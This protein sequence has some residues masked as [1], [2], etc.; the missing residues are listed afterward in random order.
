MK[1]QALPR[2]GNGGRGDRVPRQDTAASGAGSVV[3]PCGD[4]VVGSTCRPAFLEVGGLA[5][6]RR[7]GCG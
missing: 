4:G 2:G 7:A 1:R 3:F 5:G 6:F